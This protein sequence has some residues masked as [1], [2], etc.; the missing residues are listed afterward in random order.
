M[1]RLTRFIRR[2][3]EGDEGFT[4]IE[5][6]VVVLIIGI[7]V[8]IAVP[9]FLGA[10]NGAEDKAVESSLRNALT[11]AKVYYTNNN[12]YAATA[13]SDVTGFGLLEPSLTFS[14]G[15]T[16]LPNGNTIG[17]M[18]DTNAGVTATP[19]TE[20]GVCLV[21]LSKTGSYFAIMDTSDAGTYYFKG[22]AA[23]TACDSTVFTATTPAGALW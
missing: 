11:T 10:R 18:L 20:T 5:L 9:T 14:S 2:H 19:Q 23:P 22:T 6:M 13:A 16:S 1:D 3:P 8:A 15:T 17:V 4:L 12:G 21:G 7:L